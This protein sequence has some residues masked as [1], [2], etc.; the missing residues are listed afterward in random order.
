MK[1]ERRQLAGRLRARR[2]EI[3]QSVL[4]RAHSV[5][6][7]AEDGGPEYAEGLRAAVATAIDYGL[8]AIE[9]GKGN[10]PPVPAELLAQARLAARSGVSLDTVLRRYVA[11]YTRLGDFLVAEAREGAEFDPATL[12]ALLGSLSALLDRLV[13][14]V[15]DEYCRAA[16]GSTGSIEERRASHV[17][18][19]LAGEFLDASEL[20]YDFEGHHV[21]VV[22]SGREAAAA[23]RSLAGES[24][25][26]LLLVSPGE[27]VQWGWLGSSAG[28]DPES[29]MKL[30]AESVPAEASLAFGE[31]G[32]E[33]GGWRLTHRQAKAAL[34]IAQR[35][36]ASVVRYADVALLASVLQDDLLV[37][38]LRQL[39]LDPLAGERD[40]GEVLRRTLRAYLDAD[41]N[42]SSTA[43]ALRVSRSTAAGRLRAVE[44]RLGRSLTACGFELE[45]ALRLEVWERGG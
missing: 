29:L 17:R 22:A 34:S 25:C 21:G 9:L 33:L 43:A 3:E 41:R 35:G 19:L 1:A 42:V 23:V 38:S 12:Q 15:S 36:P 30:A 40:G 28:V 44:A 31:L 37:K 4:A 26:R 6:D 39:Y 20:A 18:R 11:G 24:D 8:E 13:A 7:P 10:S 2:A 5:S 32:E 45:T 27:G 14:A 16:P